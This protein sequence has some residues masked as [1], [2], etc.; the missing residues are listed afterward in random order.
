MLAAGPGIRAPEISAIFVAALL[1]GAA[2]IAADAQQPV[3]AAS[4]GR[5]VAT[6]TTLEGTVRMPAVDIDLRQ[7]PDGLAIAKTETDAAGQV[8]F[9][10]VPA[11]RYIL[12]ASKAGF[13]SR[14]S[15]VFEVRAG[16][17]V[18]V[19]LDI[20]LTFVMPAVEVRATSPSPTDSVQP[21]SMSDM[22]AGSV[23]DG[24]PQGA[25]LFRV[26]PEPHG[27][28]HPPWRQIV[29]RGKGLGGD[30]RMP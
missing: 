19:L 3:P 29:Q 5:V 28:D 15:A 10:D 18:E 9:P 27:A 22:L 17:D 1:F 4:T 25:K 26:G 30:D 23:L 12:S 16:Q 6:I 24:H 2:T 7:S 14:D 21:V 20:A 13:L 11:G 8:T